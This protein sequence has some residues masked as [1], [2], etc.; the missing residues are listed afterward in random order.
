MAVAVTTL[1]VR[2]EDGDSLAMQLLFP[3]EAAARKALKNERCVAGHWSRAM[4]GGEAAQTEDGW[5]L[6]LQYPE[7]NYNDDAPYALAPV[8]VALPENLPAEHLEKLQ[9]L[10]A[11]EGHLILRETGVEHQYEI[12]GYS[13]RSQPLLRIFRC[14]PELRRDPQD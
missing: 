8:R 6:V 13:E 1:V 2:C 10:L 11:E 12:I 3:D 9:S 14:N 5:S 4:A 7:F